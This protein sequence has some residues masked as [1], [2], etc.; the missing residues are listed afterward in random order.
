MAYKVNKDPDYFI[1]SYTGIFYPEKDPYAFFRA[2][3][4]WF[5]SMDSHLVDKYR[6]KIKVNL[7]GAGDRVTKKVITELDLEN[8]VVYTD[9]VSHADA[10][11]LS[12]QSDMVLVSTG[13]GEKTR[14]GWLPS[15]FIEYLG[16]GVPILA[17]TREGEMAKIIRETKSGNVLTSED[18]KQIQE[19]L[20]KAIDIKFYNKDGLST[21]F[22]FEGVDRYEETNVFNNMVNIIENV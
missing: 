4:T 14:P 22:T 3:R 13:T 21:D 1:I 11:R 9:R 16:C 5:N 10:I 15:K 8:E 20:E 17:I 12:K 7:I 18:H 19:I 2:L 6:K